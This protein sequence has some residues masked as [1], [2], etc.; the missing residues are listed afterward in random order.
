MTTT[1]KI[2]AVNEAE[3]IVSDVSENES[4]AD[5]TVETADVAVNSANP[6]EATGI[7]NG[8]SGIGNVNGIGQGDEPVHVPTAAE[9]S[10]SEIEKLE[11]QLVM[12]RA[13][14]KS[15]TV[16]DTVIG[17]LNN[18]LADAQTDYE[19]WVELGSDESIDYTAE[20]FPGVAELVQQVNSV[21]G[22]QNADM[23]ITNRRFQYGTVVPSGRAVSPTVR[24]V[25]NSS[26]GSTKKSKTWFESVTKN[27]VTKIIPMRGQF[28]NNISEFDAI[29]A[30]FGDTNLSMAAMST[31]TKQEKLTLAGYTFKLGSV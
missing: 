2:Q 25:G 31:D 19:E 11:R 6:G 24:T 1:D 29:L 3:E 16:I 15:A 22:S 28:A 14:L 21:I 27:G 13:G 18:V 12:A 23:M 26:S 30:S 20:W 4:D 7:D 5:D 10:L 8:P 17:F 9:H